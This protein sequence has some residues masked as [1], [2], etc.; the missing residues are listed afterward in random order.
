L[1][2]DGRSPRRDEL[3]E[4]LGQAVVALAN[5]G[6]THGDL[7]PW[8]LLITKRDLTL[9]DW[10]FGSTEHHP[11]QDLTHFLVQSAVLGG[12]W[13]VEQVAS[14]LVEP[15]GPGSAYR[16]AMSMSLPTLSGYVLASLGAPPIS[17]VS[18]LDALA[19]RTSLAT[20][21]RKR[22]SK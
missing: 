11:A 17:A 13:N 22:A 4:L 12:W 21:L 7:A 14:M 15:R 8:N 19:F 6:L 10:E 3:P 18:G 16:Q 5:A 2:E 20:R 9:I 1:I